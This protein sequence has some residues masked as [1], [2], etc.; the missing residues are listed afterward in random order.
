[1]DKNSGS[2][3]FDGIS[4]QAQNEFKEKFS[5][6]C[7]NM[8]PL[9]MSM[10]QNDKYQ[11]SISELFRYFHTV[12]ALAYHS[13]MHEAS[14]IFK[15]VED[16][17]GLLYYRQPPLDSRVLDWLLVIN[18]H[19]MGWLERVEMDDFLLDPIDSYTMNMV[20][21]SVVITRK[22][23][24]L[25][26]SVNL[27][28]I[29]KDSRS[30]SLINNE[31]HKKVKAV[32]P[33]ESVKPALKKLMLG[34]ENEQCIVCL[35]IPD[36]ISSAEATA[37]FK[38]IFLNIPIVLC[39]YRRHEKIIRDSLLAGADAFIPKAIDSD[40][41]A[42]II[43]TNA[44]KY[45]ETR[46][47]KFKK[48]RVLSRIEELKPLPGVIQEI[49]R[50]AGDPECSLRN[51]TSVIAKDTLL[52]AKILKIINSAIYGVMR[53]VSSVRTAGTLLGKEKLV[54]MC[55]Q[56]AADTIAEIDLSPYDLNLDEFYHIAQ[57]RMELMTQWYSKVAFSML[58]VLTTS[59][60]IGNLGQILISE[61]VRRQNILD[62]FHHLLLNANSTVAE[63]E[64]LHTTNKDVT[65]DILS[66]WGLNT[67]LSESIRYSFDLA[68]APDNIKPFAIANYVVYTTYQC[69][70]ANANSD[71]VNEIADFLE[72]L[73][74]N[75][76]HYKRA[77]EKI[78]NT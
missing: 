64:L 45:F 67:L 54:A 38:K 18:D 35:G 31:M 69:T 53:D 57:K 1:M 78:E 14:R 28:I 76:A 5:I 26:K 51:I 25:L 43:G 30:N 24:D 15:N 33:F 27:I 49:Q 40:E 61:E 3:P 62:D 12:K 47:L 63:I 6:L 55:L 23:H 9:I 17:L 68:G 52:S 60:L 46:G 50:Q 39:A 20:K 71:T 42:M 41:L 36:D 13:E 73:N 22:P 70:D 44:K 29:D 16:V 77:I 34:L 2:F 37:K 59:A 75:P 66:H 7:E 8:E 58:P 74:L 10:Q 48:C 4:I 72:E 11:E 65:A 56:S 21:T 32:Y 19:L